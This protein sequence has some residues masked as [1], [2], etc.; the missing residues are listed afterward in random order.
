MLAYFN[1]FVYPKLYFTLTPSTII[2]LIYSMRETNT[3]LAT[4]TKHVGTKL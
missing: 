4:E 2:Q 1:L 3:P